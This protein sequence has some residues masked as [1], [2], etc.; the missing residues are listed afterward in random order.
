MLIE[1]ASKSRT[2]IYIHPAI[3]SRPLTPAT[4]HQDSTKEE[5]HPSSPVEPTPDISNHNEQEQ[6][7]EPIAHE[8]IQ[9]VPFRGMPV[10]STKDNPE[11]SEQERESY[12]SDILTI[13]AFHARGQSL[14]E[15]QSYA[16]AEKAFSNCLKTYEVLPVESL[17]S[18]SIV[19]AQLGLAT[20]LM[21]QEK[22]KQAKDLF[23]FLAQDEGS[24]RAKSLFHLAQMYLAEHDFDNAYTACLGARAEFQSVTE[25]SRCTSLL[26]LIAQTNEDEPAAAIYAIRLQE[27]E[28]SLWVTLPFYRFTSKGHGLSVSAEREALTFIKSMDEDTTPRRP[29]NA[30]IH[31]SFT[32]HLDAVKLLVWQGA[33]LNQISTFYF[34]NRPITALMAAAY[35]G[36]TRIIE[37]LIQSGADPDI[38]CYGYENKP[39]YLKITDSALDFAIRSKSVS[40]VRAILEAMAPN[41]EAYR[42][43]I[44]SAIDYHAESV[45]EVLLAHEN[46]RE[47]IKRHPPRYSS[48][49]SALHVAIQNNAISM[50]RNLVAAGFKPSD[51]ELIQA[52]KSGDKKMIQEV[53]GAMNKTKQ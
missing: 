45:V 29:E 47:L 46:I 32:G 2:E 6:E 19:Q 8:E 30:L 26:V 33:P 31:S 3:G 40:A 52:H 14:L 43:A 22:W 27:N 39:G 21:H 28:S 11:N 50:V 10:G 13:Q 35:K 37:I 36:H 51:E 12:A 25:R 17:P 4:T 1:N 16:N 42:V 23:T 7:H 48:G 18:S 20:A 5:S 49:A 53:T 41:D 44:L 15:S 24:V 34:A 9:E 38:G